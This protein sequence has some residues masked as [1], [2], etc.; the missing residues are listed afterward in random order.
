[1][2]A[3]W[4]GPLAKTLGRPE[5]LYFG[6]KTPRRVRRWQEGA[7]GSG[8]SSR[9]GPTHF[10]QFRCHPVGMAWMCQLTTESLLCCNGHARPA[11]RLRLTVERWCKNIRGIFRAGA[12][13]GGTAVDS[14]AARPGRY[15]AMRS[16]HFARKCNL[17]RRRHNSRCR[18]S[19]LGQ[20]ARPS[21][22]SKKQDRMVPVGPPRWE[23]EMMRRR[24]QP[25][26]RSIRLPA[27]RTSS[28]PSSLCMANV[29]GN[30]INPHIPEVR[31]STKAR[32]HR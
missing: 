25:C 13:A 16:L 5:T 6:S 24:T 11:S 9:R 18:L 17:I 31:Q 23:S 30:R 29:L 7:Q 21:T 26:P 28:L 12:L 8:G 19:S 20:S 3:A 32:L 4:A 22:T 2:Q 1:V 10:R 15:L 14:M 27:N